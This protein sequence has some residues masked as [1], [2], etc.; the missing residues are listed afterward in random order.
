MVLGESRKI[1][2]SMNM[3][4]VD[5]HNWGVVPVLFMKNLPHKQFFGDVLMDAYP[6]DTPSS[7]KLTKVQEHINHI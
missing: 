6:D 1:A 3:P 7:D 4:L 2:S 5:N